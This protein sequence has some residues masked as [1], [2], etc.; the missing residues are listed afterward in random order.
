MVNPRDIAV[1]PEEEEAM[2]KKQR[3]RQV[4]HF[5]FVLLQADLWWHHDASLRGSQH[6]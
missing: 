5:P 6:E 2:T 1:K 4:H 3:N